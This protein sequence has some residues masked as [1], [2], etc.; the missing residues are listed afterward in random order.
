MKKEK[1]YGELDFVN[2]VTEANGSVGDLGELPKNVLS[3]V[4]G[5][6]FV[7]DGYSR[8]GRFYPKELWENVL[9]NKKT[10]ETLERK[11][12]FGC[13]GHPVGQYS[14][15]ELLE[16]GKVSHIVTKI[17][18]KDGK[19]IAEYHILDT[20]SGRILNSVLNAGSKLYVSTRAFGGFSSEVMK[21]EGREY[22]VLDKD[23]F[24]IESIDFVINPGFLEADPSLAE[25]F[26]DDLMMMAEDK[27][28]IKCTDGLC[29]L[30][31]TL[32]ENEKMK[33]KTNESIEKDKN[34]TSIS[35]II[36]DMDKEQIVSMITSIVDENTSLIEK[37]NTIDTNSD[38]I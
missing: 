1:L 34:T 25:S 3:V 37:Y 24:V 8:N 11:L 20:P 5:P 18:I 13:I 2:Y 23:N 7:P 28:E 19:G 6:A 33:E 38:D 15:D 30:A 9:K 35:D 22:K 21:H 29:S 12:M 14:L 32:F 10:K 26:K 36:E 31:E 17:E 4:S 27:N 16:S